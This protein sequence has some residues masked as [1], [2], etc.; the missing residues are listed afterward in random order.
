VEDITS[1]TAEY[2]AFIETLKDII[3]ATGDYER[4]SMEVGD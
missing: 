3:T 4:L 2:Q 1:S